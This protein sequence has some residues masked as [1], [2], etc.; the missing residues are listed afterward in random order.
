[1]KPPLGLYTKNRT[2]A[3]LLA[4]SLPLPALGCELADL[5]FL[6]ADDAVHYQFMQ[7]KTVAALSRP[8][9]SSGVLALSANQ[10]LV[11]QTLK[12]LKSTLVINSE[13]LQQFDRN[14]VLVSEFDLPAAQALAQVLLGVLSGDTQTL[15]AAFTQT[16]SCDGDAW[17]LQLVPA[18]AELA[19][20]ITGITLSGT[21]TAEKLTFNEARGDHTEIRVSAPL[22]QPLAKLGIYVGD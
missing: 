6:A 13:G 18:D 17:Q 21:A 11:W 14:D 12:P 22:Q 16:L 2:V 3:L 7:S 19:Q 8:L 9:L 15:E 5:A 4:A 1:M 20:V 10:A